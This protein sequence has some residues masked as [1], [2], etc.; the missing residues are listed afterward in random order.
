MKTG[1]TVYVT[2]YALTQGIFKATV[3]NVTYVTTRDG[4]PRPRYIYTQP[5][6][7]SGL[8]KLYSPREVYPDLSSALVRIAHMID[9]K[10][11]AHRLALKRL[12]E[13]AK[14]IRGIRVIE[15]K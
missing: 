8:V 6:G 12:E 4:V 14:N 11:K 1:D 2:K 9:D 10:K 7:P 3:M 13:L 15:G 5:R